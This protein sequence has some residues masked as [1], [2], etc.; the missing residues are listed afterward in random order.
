MP[1]RTP[2]IINLDEVAG[3]TTVQVSTPIAV[4]DGEGIHEV[5]DRDNYEELTVALRLFENPPSMTFRA[6]ENDNTTAIVVNVGDFVRIP[7][8]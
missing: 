3:P 8:E 5:P 7:N 4:W 6:V 2:K 1:V